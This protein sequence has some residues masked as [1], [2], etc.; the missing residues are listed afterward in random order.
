MKKNINLDDDNF[1]VDDPETI[2]H[3]RLMTWCN[4]YKQLK[5]CKKEKNKE[6]MPIAQHPKRSW[7]WCMSQDEKNKNKQSKHFFWLMKNSKS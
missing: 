7:E 6:L 3:V 2:I 5:A 1:D 4:R